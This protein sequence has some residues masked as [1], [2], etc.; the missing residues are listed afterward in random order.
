MKILEY[1][2]DQGCRKGCHPVSI[3][4]GKGRKTEKRLYFSVDEPGAWF[5]REWNCHVDGCDYPCESRRE[6]IRKGVQTLYSPQTDRTPSVV[7]IFANRPFY[8]N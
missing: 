8:D 3:R 7:L 6:A 4:T 1:H 2:T 5:E